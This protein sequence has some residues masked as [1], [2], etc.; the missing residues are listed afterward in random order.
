MASNKLFQ[1]VLNILRG[2]SPA[3]CKSEEEIV[4]ATG[5]TYCYAPVLLVTSQT[6]IEVL[7]KFQ[8]LP[9]PILVHDDIGQRAGLVVLLRA[10]QQKFMT[11]KYGSFGFTIA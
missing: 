6:L 11:G 9:T 1:S 3:Y 8:D 2:D 4:N 5:I 10:A 7:Q